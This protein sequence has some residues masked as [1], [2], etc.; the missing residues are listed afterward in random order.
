M[1]EVHTILIVEVDVSLLHATVCD[2]PESTGE[3]K[4]KGTGHIAE[5]SEENADRGRSRVGPASYLGMPVPTSF[6]ILGVR[7]K[8]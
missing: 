2:V 1:Q 4:S 8:V 5:E 7:S 6:A 3:F